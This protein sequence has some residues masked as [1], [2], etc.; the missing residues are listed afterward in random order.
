[1]R[2]YKADEFMSIYATDWPIQDV[3]QHDAPFIADDPSDITWRS[4][5][6]RYPSC[7]LYLHL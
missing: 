5:T 1:M 2:D 7:Y 3:R 4:A 6:I